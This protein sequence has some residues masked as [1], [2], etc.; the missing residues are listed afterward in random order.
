M[1]DYSSYDRFTGRLG[2]VRVR[3]AKRYVFVPR[4]ER[5]SGREKN[6][7]TNDVYFGTPRTVWWSVKNRH[8]TQ[9]EGAE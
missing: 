9:L 3:R 7:R 8:R 4:P 5:A 6:R 1:G 2:R